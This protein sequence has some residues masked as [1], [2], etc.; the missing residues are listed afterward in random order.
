VVIG[1]VQL[2]FFVVLKTIFIRLLA[3]GPAGTRSALIERLIELP[4]DLWPHP[5]NPP[6]RAPLDM[7]REWCGSVGETTAKR[8][9]PSLRAGGHR[10][11]GLGLGG[12]VE[13]WPPPLPSQGC[14]RMVEAVAKVCS[15]HKPMIEL[16]LHLRTH[17]RRTQSLATALLS[18]ARLA[19]L[20]RGCLKAHVF[21]DKEDSRRLCYSELWDAEENLCAMLRSERF[22]RLVELM[23]MSAEPPSLAFRT[24]AETRSLEFAWRARGGR[25]DFRSE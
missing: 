1:I 7:P 9:N 19:R 20:E 11:P 3:F 12:S 15:W 5:V 17:P 10:D 13:R 18:L 22:T 24:I 21:A 8:G 25:S 2:T 6:N 16:H 23:E 14:A 4:F